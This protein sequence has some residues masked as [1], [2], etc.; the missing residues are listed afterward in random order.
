VLAGQAKA[1]IL[2]DI[3]LSVLRGLRG[4]TAGT[5]PENGA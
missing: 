3:N 1:D 4:G 5:A 2:L